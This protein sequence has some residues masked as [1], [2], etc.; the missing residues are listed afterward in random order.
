MFVDARVEAFPQEIW[1]D[2]ARVVELHQDWE[3]VLDR[4]GV[5]TVV[6]ATDHHPALHAALQTSG[7]WVVAHR[8]DEGVVYVRATPLGN[9][10]L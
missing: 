2:Y 5:D 8:D 10:G 4:W 1:D 6:V 7:I 9:D 3:Q